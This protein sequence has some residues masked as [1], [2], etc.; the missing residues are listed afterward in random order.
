MHRC[1]WGGRFR[2]GSYFAASCGGAPLTVVKQYIR[3]Q[4]RPT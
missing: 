1:L 4:Q 3:R 2:S